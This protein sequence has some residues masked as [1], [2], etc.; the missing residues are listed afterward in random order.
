YQVYFSAAFGISS[1][2]GPAL[3]GFLSA[4]TGWRAVF[5]LSASL[6][7]LA[8]ALTHHQL[9]KLAVLPKRASIDWWG[10]LLI[11]AFTYLL[12]TY[13]N[14]AQ[15]SGWINT[16]VIGYAVAS[17]IAL[18]ALVWVSRKSETPMFPVQLFARPIFAASCVI[19]LLSSMVMTG[20]IVTLPLIYTAF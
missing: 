17:I 11:A 3:G 1:L 4:T 20:M 16:H 6:G 18:V 14:E 9:R 2:S 7:I 8:L 13:V 5:W 10:S 12:V 19:T 15:H